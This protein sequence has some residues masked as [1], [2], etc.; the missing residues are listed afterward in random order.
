V[1]GGFLGPGG[2]WLGLP[3]GSG[4]SGGSGE[5]EESGASGGSRASCFHEQT[6]HVYLATLLGFSLDSNK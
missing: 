2:S 4:A 6:V 1:A 3:G 5:P